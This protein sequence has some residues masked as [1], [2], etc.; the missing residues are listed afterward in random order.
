MRHPL[1]S[2]R[3][4]KRWL[5]AHLRMWSFGAHSQRHFRRDPRYDLQ[6]VSDG[7]A[8]HIDASE[9]DTRLLERI[10]AAY[11][12]AQGEAENPRSQSSGLRPY[13]EA[14]RHKDAPALSR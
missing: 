13:T 11:N 5:A 6:N 12:H 4:A 2:V 3:T 8:P 7:F 9:V 14:L 1:H 10:C